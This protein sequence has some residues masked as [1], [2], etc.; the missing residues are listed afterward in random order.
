MMMCACVQTSKRMFVCICVCELSGGNY[1][2]FCFS[3]SLC[4]SVCLCLS[5]SVCLSLPLSLSLSL[6][7][8]V[9]LS[10][11]LSLF[12]CSLI[13]L[14]PLSSRPSPFP[15]FAPLS[16]CLFVSLFLLLSVCRGRSRPFVYV[17][18]CW[19]MGGCCRVSCMREGAF[20]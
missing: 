19:R 13:S 5:L 4:L 18:V 20:V 7:A 3:V 15:I 11:S 10:L 6:L 16:V 17:C 14:S 1:V 9:S 2:V 8:P 12:L